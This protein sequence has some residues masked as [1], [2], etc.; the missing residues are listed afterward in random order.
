[1][2]AIFIPAAASALLLAG[3]ACA[4]TLQGTGLEGKNVTFPGSSSRYVVEFSESGSSKFRK[5]DGSADTEGFYEA[6]SL[7]NN[8]AVPA[9][10]FTSDV[11]HGASFDLVNGTAQSLEEIENLSEVLKVWPVSIVYAPT[12]DETGNGP[13]ISKW[14]PHV[15]TKVNDVHAR[16]FD[17]SD[18]IIAVV[19]SGIDYTHP[20]L[21]GGFGAN[22]KVE[23][24]WDFVGDAYDVASPD[25]LYPDEDPKDCM[26]HGTHVAGIIASS[27]KA[28]PGV[29]PNARLRAYKV[30]GCGDGTTEDVIV[31]A[32]IRA[33]EDGADIITA[34]LGSNRGFPENMVAGVIQRI[35]EKGVFVSAA[36][37][38]SGIM[39]PYFTS[40]LGNGNGGLTV[41]S[42]GHHQQTA[43]KV[44]AKSSSGESREI[45]YVSDAGTQWE[46]D[47]T[48][49]A[50]IP[51]VD[52]DFD[53][54]W[55]DVPEP[56][57]G[58][59]R[60]DILVL[61]RGRGIVCDETWQP[62]DSYLIGK[63]Q[64]VFFYNYP[65]I[66][67]EQPERAIYRDDQPIGFAAIN[68][69]DGIWIEEQEEAGLTVK[70]EFV[71]D[72][73]NAIGI[74]D[75]AVAIDEFSSWG[76]TLDGR[77]KPEISAPGGR[78]LSTYLTNSG[79]WAVF[80]GTSMA[81]P[82]IAG[83]AAL[84]FNSVG[85]RS[86]LCTN[87][88]AAAHRRIVASGRAVNHW[89]GTDV[90]G[91][92]AQQGAGLVDALKVVTFDTTVFPANIN[93]NDTANFS[94]S[95]TITIKNRGNESVTYELGHQNGVTARSREFADA[96]V[97]FEPFLKTDEGLASV[98]FSA[99]KVT[100]PAKGK[101][102]FDVSFTA[103]DDVDAGVLA[104]Y[105]GYLHVV[106]SNGETVKVTYMGIKGNLRDADFW[107]TERGVPVFFGQDGF[108]DVIEDGRKFPF[109][110]LPDVYFNTLWS[111]RE[112][113]FD[114]VTPDFDPETDWTYPL[115]PG[116]NNFVGIATYYDA[117]TS[118]YFPFPMTYFP[119]SSGVFWLSLGANYTH[120]A[121]VES[122][123]YRILARALRTYGDYQDPSGWQFRLSPTFV[124]GEPE[125][126]D[127][128]APEGS[129]LPSAP[130]PIVS[131]DLP[132]E[133]ATSSLPEETN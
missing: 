118:Q 80:S 75:A 20:D 14:D 122:G 129:V 102:T 59:P 23:S 29:A 57:G 86:R 109:P 81:T 5:R 91:S 71:Y 60:D 27:N 112:F 1:M 12:P 85:G 6:V 125:G 41:G 37:G 123:E 54:C 115:V 124:V 63:V 7:T 11:F 111:T 93:L 103:P 31:E 108:G 73:S 131:L 38:N 44:V 64:W 79:S 90:L 72:P 65:N 113:S 18:V 78:I 32:I 77:M 56:Q 45:Y 8:T 55:D 95:H 106:G 9:L 15:L 84:F 89:N 98:K 99:S 82:Y 87:A 10:N 21:G 39:G 88:A 53:A 3:S 52:R 25:V 50:Y 33:Y 49:N 24:G 68:Y 58:I 116:K 110:S 127:A 126:G 34:S 120:G 48:Y 70:F 92:V 46:R 69:E 117:W 35:T 40:S 43:Y 96:W 114:I 128:P 107:E 76:A 74:K 42:V 66:S 97:S 101:A 19:D 62:M 130:A 61:P 28:L 26:G 2:V 119:R 30:F 104:M 4:Q 121:P 133:T 83:V 36:A 51:P 16:G 17:G 100:V 94:G 132:T 67:Y 47:G 105:G 13:E 22:F